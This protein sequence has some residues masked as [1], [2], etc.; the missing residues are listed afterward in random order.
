MLTG[1]ISQEDITEVGSADLVLEEI[2]DD[3]RENFT[4]VQLVR[5]D[6]AID[7]L[8]KNVLEGN[9]GV[10][11]GVFEAMDATQLQLMVWK[12]LTKIP[13]G[14]TISYE[15]L[16]ERVGKPKAVRAVASACGQQPF[17][18]CH[19]LPPRYPQEWGNWRVP[20][21]TGS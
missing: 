10:D 11:D 4:M 3:F 1:F 2:M 8:L 18:H 17:K 20:L 21:G 12:E 16:A 13:Y 19:S 15:Q 9:Y 6:A 5:D 7:A 14:Q